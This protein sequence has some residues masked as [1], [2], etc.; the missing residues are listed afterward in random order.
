M[1]QGSQGL[2]AAQLGLFQAE[3]TGEQGEQHTQQITFAA[4]PQCSFLGKSQPRRVT[5]KGGTQ[6]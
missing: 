2:A 1:V 6:G 4:S 5:I 3:A